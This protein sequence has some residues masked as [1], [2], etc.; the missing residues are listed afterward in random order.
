MVECGQNAGGTNGNKPKSAI[1]D[2]GS[3][4][5]RSRAMEAGM[6][7]D[8]VV[9]SGSGS[10]AQGRSISPCPSTASHGDPLLPVAEN[11]CHTQVK[12]VKFNYMWTINNF[13]FC[14]EEMGEVLKSSTFSAG[15]NDK[16]KWCLRINPKGLDEESRDYLSLYLLLV[17]CNKS[18]VRAKFKF[19]I[20]NAKREE[21]KAMESQRAYRFV[22]GKDWGFKKFIRRDFLLD[23]ANGLLP[24]DRLSIFCEVSVVAETVNVTG[25]TNV[26]QLFKVPPCRLADDMQG[27]FDKQQFSD[28]TLICKSD[29][30]APP[31]TF[32]IHKAIVSARSRVFSAMFEH[33]MQE[34]DTNMTTV[35]DIDPDVMRELLVYM[36]TGQARY[37][38]QMA[39]S[40]IAAADKYQLDRLK[41]MCEQALCYQLTTENACLTLVLADMYSA[42]QLRAHAINFINVNAAEVMSSEG[43]HGLVRDHPKLLEEVF[44]ALAMQQTPPV[45][46]VQPPKKRPKHNC[47]Y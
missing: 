16:L 5:S 38:D 13:S 1:G 47:P 17:Q 23:E 40:L 30:G 28:F 11:W 39:Q 24:G 44:R 43:W 12:V 21:T 34:S 14:R 31:Q 4:G 29:N 25:Q 42:A 35:D 41:V 27:L 10:S 18:E 8:E 19:S 36:Y 26:T 32:Y 22:Q 3:D 20:L 15:C 37:I 33:H 7:N 45:V 6:I 9:S 2:W 46:L